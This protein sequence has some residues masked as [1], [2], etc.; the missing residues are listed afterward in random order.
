[1]ISQPIGFLIGLDLGVASFVWLALKEL[2][3][4]A[5]SSGVISFAGVDSGGA[6]L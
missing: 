3:S 6:R 2:A 5:L 4:K 1:M